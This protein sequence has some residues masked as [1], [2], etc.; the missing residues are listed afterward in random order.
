M[1]TYLIATIAKQLVASQ[2][3]VTAAKGT[4]QQQ[5]FVAQVRVLVGFLPL[6]LQ[7]Q[8]SAVSL[9]GGGALGEAGRSMSGGNG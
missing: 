2:S 7:V 9:Y 1:G 4:A 6:R 5:E 8:P 3:N